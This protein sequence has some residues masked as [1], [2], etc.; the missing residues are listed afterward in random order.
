MIDTP[1]RRFAG[2]VLMMDVGVDAV[3]PRA[4]FQGAMSR[5]ARL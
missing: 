4:M 3:G 5:F 1:A 2:P